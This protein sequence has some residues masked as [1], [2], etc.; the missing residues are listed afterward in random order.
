MNALTDFEDP[1]EILAHLLVGS[2]GTLGFISEVT[3][4]TVEDHPHKASTLVVFPDAYTCCEAVAA[5]K[6]TPVSAVELMGWAWHAFGARQARI[7][8]LY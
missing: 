6:S 1:I 8:R 2:E 7:A 3:Y 4:H 5:L